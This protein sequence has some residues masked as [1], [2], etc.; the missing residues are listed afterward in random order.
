MKSFKTNNSSGVPDL[1][2]LQQTSE[3]FGHMIHSRAEEVFY[4]EQPEDIQQVINRALTE[5]KKVCIR[6]LAGSQSGQSLA[7]PSSLLMD[8]SKMQSSVEI[9]PYH[10]TALCSGTV[11]W[12]QLI[13]QTIPYRLIPSVIPLNTNLSVAGTLSVGGISTSSYQYGTA[14]SQVE[15]L[16]IINAEAKMLTCNKIDNN[17]FFKGCLSNLGRCGVINKVKLALKETCA[18]VRTY[19][20]LYD[21]IQ[22]WLQDQF[23]LVQNKKCSHL[24]GSCAMNQQG[25]VKADPMYKPLIHWFYTLQVSFEFDQDEALSQDEVLKGLNFYR[26]LHVEDDS[27]QHF[28]QRYDARFALMEKTGMSK[29]AH[30]WL[31]CILPLEGLDELLPSILSRLPLSLGDN[32]RLF[33]LAKKNLPDFFMTPWQKDCVVFA[34]LPAAVQNVFLEDALKSIHAVHDMVVEAG[35]KRYL[36]GWL[37]MMKPE[38]WQKHYGDK[39]QAWKEI[40]HKLDPQGI[41]TSY[42]FKELDGLSGS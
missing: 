2:T 7:Y 35:G 20:L 34:V 40:K 24:Q 27:L 30:P 21:D 42:L 10:K 32:H 22:A 31:E 8:L 13:A 15:E 29:Q 25:L 1:E 41:F 26:F 6:S 9:N 23:M 37:G 19:Y 17:E 38:D 5:N 4:P 16:E 14:A 33:F 18:N 3:D 36:S 28:L 39:Y 12:R 11:S